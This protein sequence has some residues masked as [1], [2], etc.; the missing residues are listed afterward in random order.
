MQTFC[1]ELDQTARLLIQGQIGEANSRWNLALGQ[2]SQKLQS[3]PKKEQMACLP[4]L[5]QI[6]A[7][8]Q[9]EDWVGMSDGLRHVLRPALLRNLS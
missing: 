2:L 5:R 3:F 6:L 8:Q 9:N 1:D 4:A 7:C